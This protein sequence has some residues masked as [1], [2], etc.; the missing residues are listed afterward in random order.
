MT[1]FR[2]NVPQGLPADIEEKKLAA[3]TWFETLRD[4]ICAKFEELEQELTGPGSDLDAGKFERSEWHRDGEGGGGVMSMMHGR[5]F[6]KVGVHT[7]TVYGEF[8]EEFRKQIPGAKDD[9]RFWASGISLIAHPWNPHV[10]T[11]HMNTRM[12]VTTG[13]WF[14]GG[15]DLTPVLGRAAHAGAPRH[16]RLPQGDEVRLRPAWAVADYPDSSNGATSISS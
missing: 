9:P 5:V 1:G 6:E 16:A 13:N 2:P 7:S 3:R 11:V 4:Q 8:C 15:A 10:P 14:G 12:V